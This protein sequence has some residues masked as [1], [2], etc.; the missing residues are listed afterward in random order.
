MLK[1]VE[2]NSEEGFVSVSEAKE[3]GT[4]WHTLGRYLPRLSDEEK[5]MVVSI[6]NAVCN[7]CWDAPAGCHCWNDE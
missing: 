7:E 2:I 1:H 3:R 6:I 4:L 5:A